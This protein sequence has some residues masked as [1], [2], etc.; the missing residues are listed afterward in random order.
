MTALHRFRPLPI[1]LAIG[2]ALAASLGGGLWPPAAMAQQRQVSPRVVA[3][4]GDHIVAIVNQELVTAVELERRQ[5]ALRQS[6]ARA[7]QPVPPPAQLRQQALDSLVEERVIVTHARDLGWRIDDAELDRAV[8][9]VAAQNQMTL[10]QL[11]ER[12]QAEG[13]DMARFRNNLRDQIAVERTREREVID[14]IIVTDEDIDTALAQEQR[15]A[16]DQAEINVAQILVAVPE[17]ADAALV[18]ER[19]AR[20]GEVLDRLR[21]GEAFADL[22]ILKLREYEADIAE[23][24]GHLGRSAL[25]GLVAR[26]LR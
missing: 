2:L 1:R 12:L 18:A 24:T 14:R 10:P 6:A 26:R 23:G 19:R 4:P 8:Q 3:T 11:R 25:I 22:E 21:A 13:I 15:A 17:G 20:A 7:G 5:Q 16:R 9:S